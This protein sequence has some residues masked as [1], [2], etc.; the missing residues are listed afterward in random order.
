MTPELV[1]ALSE[2]GHTGGVR[3]C[4]HPLVDH[5]KISVRPVKFEVSV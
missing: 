5:D 1:I 3:P 4:P 2:I